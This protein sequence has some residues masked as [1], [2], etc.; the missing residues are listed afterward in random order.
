MPVFDNPVTFGDNVRIDGR[1]YRGVT[2]GTSD[3]QPFLVNDNMEVAGTLT[4]AD[5]LGEGVVST[6][7]IAD[8]V[9]AAVDLADGAV[10]T[11][12]IADGTIAAGRRGRGGGAWH[13]T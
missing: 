12:K 10:N 8:G 11:A 4:V 1:V 6:G 13:R 2:A 5:L 3:S 7:N 9:V